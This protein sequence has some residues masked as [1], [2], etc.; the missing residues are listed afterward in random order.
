MSRKWQ[1]FFEKTTRFRYWKATDFFLIVLYQRNLLRLPRNHCLTISCFARHKGTMF[2]KRCNQNQTKVE[3]KL[4]GDFAWSESAQ[5]LSDL[6][7]YKSHGM[8]LETCPMSH[9]YT[10]YFIQ[11]I[12]WSW[13]SLLSAHSTVN[14][15]RGDSVPWESDARPSKIRDL[16]PFLGGNYKKD[17]PIFIGSLTRKFWV[18]L[19]RLCKSHAWGMHVI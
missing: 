15:L 17:H 16:I 6:H 3:E 13:I 10:F 7:T 19:S 11:G 2:C 14:I 12:F 1:S 18:Y 9:S 5:L 4:L 8:K